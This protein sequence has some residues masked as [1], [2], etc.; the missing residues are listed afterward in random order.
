MLGLVVVLQEL[1]TIC[2]YDHRRASPEGADIIVGEVAIATYFV[3][4][5]FNALGHNAAPRWDEWEVFTPMRCGRKHCT[6]I[7]FI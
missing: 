4:L 5:V 1:E 3:A 6:G 7:L 2:F